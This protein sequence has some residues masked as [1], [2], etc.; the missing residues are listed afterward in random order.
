LT[1]TKDVTYWQP[2]HYKLEFKPRPGGSTPYFFFDSTD[3]NPAVKINNVKLNLNTVMHSLEVEIDNSDGSVNPTW[4]QQGTRVKL[5]IWK[6]GSVTD[7]D[8]I[9]IGCIDYP[10][11]ARVGFELHKFKVP[12]IELKQVLYDSNVTFVKNA[13][14]DELGEPTTARAR[15][16]RLWRLIKDLLTNSDYTLLGDDTLADRV[17]GSIT[18]SENTGISQRVDIIFPKPRIKGT[19]AGVGLDEWA[20]LFGFNWYFRYNYPGNEGGSEFMLRWPSEEYTPIVMK[21]GDTKDINSDDVLNTSYI[22]EEIIKESSSSQEGN[23]ANVISAISKIQNLIM[24]QSTTND[25]STLMNFKA[26]AMPFTTNETNFTELDLLMSKQ[27]D[28]ESPKNRV[29]GAIFVNVGNKPIGK[30]LDFEIP[31]NDI[32]DQPTAVTVDLTDRKRFMENL[33]GQTNFYIVIYQRSGKNG[34]PNHDTVDGVRWHRDN[35]TTGGSLIADNGDKDA[36]STLVWKTHGPKYV[37]V[38][39]SSINRLFVSTNQESVIQVGKKEPQSLDFGFIEDVNTAQRYVSSILYY[40]SLYKVPIPLKVTVPNDFL[41][42]PYQIIPAVTVN[43]IMPFGIDLEIQ[44]V[45]YNLSENTN[46]CSLVC[47]AIVDNSFPTTF[48]CANLV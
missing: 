18:V 42:Q 25:T 27:G 24:A 36:H 38:V 48:G 6:N 19:S 29:N 34:D 47:L 7:S 13:P 12:I 15:N 14:L 40:A 33:G 26:I 21:A 41:F 30:V 9:F 32:E 8:Y 1:F 10:N 4:V 28:P 17:P 31:L 39:K 5:Q 22:T 11:E 16:Y 2:L 23:F 3:T 43:K 44:E 37:F 45:E 20:E 46:E 35:S